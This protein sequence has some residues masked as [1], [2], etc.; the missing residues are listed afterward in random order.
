ML[1]LGRV[2]KKMVLTKQSAKT[3]CIALT[4]ATCELIQHKK[5]TTQL[6]DPP[7]EPMKLHCSDDP[8]VTHIAF[9]LDFHEG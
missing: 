4:L 5:L 3:M 6:G 8:D 7:I 1:Y 2:R 9:N